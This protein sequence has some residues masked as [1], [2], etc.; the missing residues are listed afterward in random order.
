MQ[1][2][3]TEEDSFSKIHFLQQVD[4]R[5]MGVR[6]KLF[7]PECSKLVDELINEKF[8]IKARNIKKDNAADFDYG[9]SFPTY[10]EVIAYMMTNLRNKTVLEVGAADGTESLFLACSKRPPKHIYVNDLS[11]LELDAFENKKRRLPNEHL[12]SSMTSICGS[13]LEIS[14]LNPELKGSIDKL[15][16]RNVFHFFNEQKRQEFFGVCKWLLKPGAEIILVVNYP[17]FRI[18]DAPEKSTNKD[19]EMHTLYSL[20]NIIIRSQNTLSPFQIESGFN[21]GLYAQEGEES[22]SETIFKKLES[23]IN[24][25][26]SDKVEEIPQLHFL[27]KMGKITVDAVK[28]KNWSYSPLALETMFRKPLDGFKV[29]TTFKIN[30]EGHIL[31][32]IEG[33]PLQTGIIVQYNPS[34]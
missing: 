19:K 6:D 20:Y 3:K 31:Q 32:G 9:Y 23:T 33:Y 16:V 28:S 34:T 26:V 12:K 27:M 8:E 18:L 21:Y 2:I 11:K 24:Q 25:F 15:L 5:D 4:L 30:P 7:N 17:A 1:D 29:Q 13:I 14:K 22:S 10:P